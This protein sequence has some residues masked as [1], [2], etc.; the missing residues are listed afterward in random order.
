MYVFL[1]GVFTLSHNRRIMVEDL[2][3]VDNDTISRGYPYCTLT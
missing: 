3:I 2:L 1:I